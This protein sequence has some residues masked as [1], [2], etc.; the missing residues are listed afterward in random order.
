MQIRRTLA[1]AILSAL[2]LWGCAKA[3]AAFTDAERAAIRAVIEDFTKAVNTGDFAAA[4]SWYA[5]DGT[6][7]PPN[8]AAVEGRAGIQK[9]FESM[10]RPQAFS[11]P[12]VEI[13]GEGNLAYA[14]LT[15]DLTLTPTNAK[16]PVN[17]KGKILIVMRKESDGKWRTVRGT[18]N[19]NLPVAR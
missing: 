8:G 5:E 14:R 4:A 16:A 18:W 19:S 2:G 12:V 15:Y 6:I 10:G 13:D 11:Q 1:L 3:P 9:W 17:D 7:M